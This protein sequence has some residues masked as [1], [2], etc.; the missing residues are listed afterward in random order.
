MIINVIRV[1]SKLLSAIPVRKILTLPTSP[2]SPA[3][4][5]SIFSI[6]LA[7]V[8]AAQ[9]SQTA[10]HAW[11]QT[12][13]W[14]VSTAA[15]HIS[16]VT[17]PA[18]YAQIS[19]KDANSAQTINAQSAYLDFFTI[20]LYH[21]AN[22][23]LEIILMDFVQLLPDALPQLITP[24]DRKDVWVAIRIFSISGLS[25]INANANNH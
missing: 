21:N 1:L 15:L 24:M 13:A 4:L 10:A 5:M 9:W 18:S 25:I 14:V 16:Q 2:V 12:I 19:F 7:S 11:I 3:F 6:M 17:M 20:S 23:S 22:V 8:K